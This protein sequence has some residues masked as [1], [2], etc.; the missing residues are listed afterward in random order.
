MTVSQLTGAVLTVHGGHRTRVGDVAR[1]LGGIQRRRQRLLPAPAE[2]GPS[3]AGARVL[4]KRYM[5]CCFF[6]CEFQRKE[7]E[8]AEAELAQLVRAWC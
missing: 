2:E 5:K 7:C 1:L 3:R 8:R 4:E 6:R